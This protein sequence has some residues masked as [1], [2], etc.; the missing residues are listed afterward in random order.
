MSYDA[1]AALLVQSGVDL[2]PFAIALAVGASLAYMATASK[3]Q[4]DT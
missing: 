4:A 2:I 1:A 3:S